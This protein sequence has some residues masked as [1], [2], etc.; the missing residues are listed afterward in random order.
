MQNALIEGQWTNFFAFL[1]Y[2]R[3]LNVLSLKEDDIQAVTSYLADGSFY[4]HSL[5]DETC[6][7]PYKGR[8]VESIKLKKGD[9]AWY[10]RWGN[11]E[12]CLVECLPYTEEEY[13]AFCRERGHSPDDPDFHPFDY[14][15]DCYLVYNYGHDHNHPKCWDLFPFNDT[16]TKRNMDRLL[17][18]KKWWDDGCPR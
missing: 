14:S 7:K 1:I 11:I 15:D 2:E 18:T 8:P 3:Q 4:C 10:W 12:P 9:L 5:C 6:E 16:I 13:A 17:A